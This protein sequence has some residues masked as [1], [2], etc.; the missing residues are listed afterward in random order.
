MIKFRL[1]ILSMYS[2]CHNHFAVKDIGISG[3]GSAVN[4]WPNVFPM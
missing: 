1:N 3:Y 4:Q 2:F